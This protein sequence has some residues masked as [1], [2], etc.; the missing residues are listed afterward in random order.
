MKCKNRKLFVGTRGQ[1][2]FGQLC[3]EWAKVKAVAK[4]TQIYLHQPHHKHVQ[5]LHLC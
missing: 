2:S 1:E 4:G 5:Q 3:E